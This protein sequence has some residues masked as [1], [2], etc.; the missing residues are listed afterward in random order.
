MERAAQQERRA[1]IE[2][3]RVGWQRISLVTAH[4][5]L[6]GKY[7]SGMPLIFRLVQVHVIEPPLVIAENP[8]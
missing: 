5:Q 3:K 2:A 8:S 4:R 7:F 6:E 1:L